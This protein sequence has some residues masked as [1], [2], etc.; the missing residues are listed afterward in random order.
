MK[1]KFKED[2]DTMRYGRVKKGDVK[3]VSTEDGRAFCKNG[4][5]E[6]VKGE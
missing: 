6:K 2:R 1:V 5:A 4:V 3:E